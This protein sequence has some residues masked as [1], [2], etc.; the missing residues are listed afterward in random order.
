MGL[1][2][3]QCSQC[4]LCPYL[5]LS[6]WVS[7]TILVHPFTQQTQIGWL[8]R[9]F[10]YAVFFVWNAHLPLINS[11]SSFFFGD[12][13][14]GPRN[15][16]SSSL[17]FSALLTTCSFHSFMWPLVDS[18]NELHEGR[19]RFYFLLSP[20]IA[21][22]LLCSSKCL[23]YSLHLCGINKGMVRTQ[24]WTAHFIPSGKLY[25]GD[26]RKLVISTEQEKMLAIS[27][28]SFG[29][30]LNRAAEEGTFGRKTMSCHSTCIWVA[31]FFS[32]RNRQKRKGKRNKA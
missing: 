29:G 20:G 24:M 15:Q 25:L 28:G 18:T 17:L 19:A 4:F 21:Q 22:S 31:W 5:E 30:P 2:S 10:G 9:T 8:L 1:P 3:T 16:Q 12:I 26:R 32:S 6:C 11:F 13:F 27:P 23:L 7:S 14:H